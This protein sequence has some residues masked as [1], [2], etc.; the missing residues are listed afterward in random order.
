MALSQIVYI[1]R[2]K[3]WNIGRKL[4]NPKPKMSLEKGLRNCAQRL[5][6]IKVLKVV[7]GRINTRARLVF[8]SMLALGARAIETHPNVIKCLIASTKIKKIDN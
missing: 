2:E 5:T 1:V 6:P 8:M 7:F 4:R 3:L